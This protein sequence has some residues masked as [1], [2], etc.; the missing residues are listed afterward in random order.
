MKKTLYLL[1]FMLM[2]NIYVYAQDPLFSSI[3]DVKSMLNPSL[4]SFQNGNIEAQ[5]NYREQG[6]SGSNGLPLRNIHASLNYATKIFK[7]DKLNFGFSIANDKGGQGHF[8][9][10]F[11]NI[12]ASY[13][14]KLT[15]YRS[16]FG[17]QFLSIGIAS[18][19][20][21]YAVKWDRFW[22]GNQY[23]RQ[24][25]IVDPNMDS[26]EILIGQGES[27]STNIFADINAGISWYAFLNEN[28]SAHAGVGMFHLN[29][30]NVSFADF[31]EEFL[32]VRINIH[33]GINWRLSELI[34]ISPQAALINQRK[35][36]QLLVGA[37]FTMENED[38]LAIS[39]SLGFFLRGVDG[40]NGPGPDALIFSV[41]FDYQKI[42]FGL[43]YD[44]TISSLAIYNSGRGAWEL[45]LYYLIPSET[46][47]NYNRRNTKFNF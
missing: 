42:R 47:K 25:G 1:F 17:E 20:G 10:N 18:G 30:P 29:T 5:I 6:S 23:N 40:L 13:A 12:H 34:I 37:D 31:D 36:R 16:P 3:Q 45:N 39:P 41:M 7:A 4:F 44:V 21:Q 38:Y 22:F 8:T 46:R 33:G 26:G 28:L 19:G 27:A 9:R 2:M 32:P 43:V 35:S 14:K 15:D 24:F 11:A